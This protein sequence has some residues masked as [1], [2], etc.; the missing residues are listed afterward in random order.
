MYNGEDQFGIKIVTKEDIEKSKKRK[1]ILILIASILIFIILVVVITILII[2]YINSKAEASLP[3]TRLSTYDWTN[4]PITLT[5]DNQEINLVSYSFDGGK[6]WQNE[7]AIQVSENGIYIVVV[8][9]EKGKVS[10]KATVNV[11]NI[12]KE[13]PNIVLTDP[14]YIQKN[15][16]YNQKTAISVT[17][18]GSGVKEYVS[19]PSIIDTSIDGEYIVTYTAYDHLGNL[20]QKTRTVIVRNLI[21]TT[22]YRSRSVSTERYRCK[23]ENCNSEDSSC[24]T[25]C[26]RNVYGQWSEWTKEEIK[27]S[28][29]LEVETK[30]E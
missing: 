4:Q 3:V 12:D 11:S 6:T 27:P 7:N 21:T 5:V 9:N 17:D 18:N 1:K 15:G 26:K 24:Y 22:Y 20:S 8:K 23:K 29:K 25:T 28:D 10:Q 19:D 14:L 2:N 16:V 13:G 30:I